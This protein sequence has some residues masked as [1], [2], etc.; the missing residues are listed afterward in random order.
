[1][2]LDPKI[3]EEGGKFANTIVSELKAQPLSL[4]LILLNIIFVGFAIFLA[5]TINQRTIH[6]YEVK[7][8]LIQD[9]FASCVKKE[10]KADEM[11]NDFAELLVGRVRSY[12]TRAK[13]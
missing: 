6:Q 12:D 7:D 1:M 10:G 2:I 5:H 9:L 13:N 8:Q 4:A 11:A 3:V